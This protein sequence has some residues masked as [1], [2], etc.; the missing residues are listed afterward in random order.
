MG[1]PKAGVHLGRRPPLG[2]ARGLAL[3]VLTFVAAPACSDGLGVED[4]F[5]VWNTQT[6]N[7]Y[8]VPGLVVYEGDT[9]DA[10]Y[11]RWTFYDGG[12]CTLTQQVDGVTA[13][14]DE[15]EYTV[16]GDLETLTMMFLSEQ[17]DGRVAGSTMTLTDPQAIEW[18]LR[19]Q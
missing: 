13:T 1:S 19:A 15:C 3:G 18:V 6:I 4:V 10:Q 2:V 9:Y 14:Y 11:V 16:N 12:R 7:G 17:W 8:P 5:G